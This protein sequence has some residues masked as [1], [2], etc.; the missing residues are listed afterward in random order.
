MHLWDALSGKG[1]GVLEGHS[2]WVAALAWSSD[3]LKLAS[4]SHDGTV[5]VLDLG[6][7][8]LPRVLRGH[9]AGVTSVVWSPDRQ[10]VASGSADRTIRVWDVQTGRAVRLLRGHSRGILSIDWSSDGETI[11]SGSEDLTVRIWGW[12]NED[13]GLV[14]KGHANSITCVRWCKNTRYLV[15]MSLDGDVRLW[16]ANTGFLESTMPPVDWSRYALDVRFGPLHQQHLLG[17]SLCLEQQESSDNGVLIQ[18][19]VS[20]KVLLLGESDIGKTTLVRCFERGLYD[21]PAST[22]G[23][24]TVRVTPDQCDP[25]A[26]LPADENREIVLWDFGGQRHYQLV[27]QAFL[28]DA[29]LALVLFDATRDAETFDAVREWHHRLCASS[30]GKSVTK[31]LVRTKVD[32]GGVVS[33]AELHR[34]RAECAFDDY[35]EISAKSGHNVAHLGEQ[36]NQRI[37]WSMLARVSRTS[38][39]RR[40]QEAVNDLRSKGKAIVYERDLL[41]DVEAQIGQRELGTVL[42]QL[43]KQGELVTVQFSDRAERVIVLRVDVVERYAGSLIVAARQH[44]RGVPV[45]EERAI[46]GMVAFPGLDDRF[47]HKQRRGEDCTRCGD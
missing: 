20:A 46:A 1:L 40:V 32:L 34:L 29:A 33:D 23:M 36:I 11:A 30:G 24:Q 19:S 16:N 13:L 15:T 14:L 21:P 35:I 41:K 10:F 12:H 26:H 37:D 28:H 42:E 38:G 39:F 3:G 27:H 5:R 31:I 43:A 9:S 45:L 2:S 47:T 22:H 44:P 6:S 4:A 17:S 8:R 18:H 7:D 25:R